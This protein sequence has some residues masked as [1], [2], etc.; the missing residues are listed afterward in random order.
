MEMMLSTESNGQQLNLEK[1]Y[2]CAKNW[3]GWIGCILW[4][5]DHD[6][7]FACHW[8]DFVC[9]VSINKKDTCFSFLYSWILTYSCCKNNFNIQRWIKLTKVGKF[10]FWHLKI[11]WPHALTQPYQNRLFTKEIFTFIN[12]PRLIVGKYD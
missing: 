3:S 4:V 5:N 10:W 8:V 9:S 7:M 6:H 2:G 12:C 11:L 1:K